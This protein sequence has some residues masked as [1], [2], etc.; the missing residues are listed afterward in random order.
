MRVAVNHVNLARRSS[1]EAPNSLTIHAL[2][3]SL[4]FNAKASTSAG[5]IRKSEGAGGFELAAEAYSGCES[6]IAKRLEGA[7]S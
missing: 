1:S 6:P 3:S 5:S 4:G 7:G 2:P